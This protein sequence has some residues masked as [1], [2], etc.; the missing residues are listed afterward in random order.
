MGKAL[1]PALLLLLFAGLAIGSV[2]ESSVT[3]DEVAHLP[4]GYT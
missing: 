1:L 2:W 4:A 3:G